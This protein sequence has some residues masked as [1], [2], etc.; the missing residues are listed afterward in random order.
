MN[1]IAVEIAAIPKPVIT[2]HCRGLLEAIGNFFDDPRNQA[3][4]EAWHIEKY[5]CPP[6]ET[7]YKKE[8]EE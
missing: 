5:G 7:S 6:R 1:A 3:K 4:F 2:A 8:V